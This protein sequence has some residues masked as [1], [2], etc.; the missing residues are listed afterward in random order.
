VKRYRAVVFDWDGTIMDSTHSIVHAI[1][2]ACADLSLPVP[3][4]RDASWVIGLS[5]ES[6]LRRAVPTLTAAQLPDFLE[7]YKAHF[8]TRDPEIQ[9]FEGVKELLTVLRSRSI[10]LGVATG[11]SRRGLDRA[12]HALQLHAE[13]ELT[14]CAD[15]SFSKPH[16]AMLLD[17]VREMRLEP[18]EVIMVGD[19][20]HDIQMANSAGTD[21]M[22]VT[23]GAHDD[24]TLRAAGPT[25]M[26]STVAEMRTWLLERI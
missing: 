19:T 4:A 15:E 21:S 5:L 13:F 8:L 26:V 20:C 6:A 23:Y 7:R 22:A 1:Q 12:L 2:A 18:G 16:P 24:A 10:L 25:V 9:L 17:V 11:K 14:R 3:T